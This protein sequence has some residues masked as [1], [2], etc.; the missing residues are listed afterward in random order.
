METINETI[1]EAQVVE[2]LRTCFD[3][4]IPVNIYD[5]GLIYDVK[6]ETDGN[7]AVQMT[8]TSPHCP[9]VQSLPAEVEEKVKA[10]QGVTG[11]KIDL[12]WDPPWDQNKMSEAARLQLGMM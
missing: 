1:I 5:L 9:A 12:V 4:E 10:V 11:A 7:V 8:L 3:P 6:V 2:A